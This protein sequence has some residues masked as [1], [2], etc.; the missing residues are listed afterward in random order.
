MCIVI[1][2]PASSYD[3][4]SLR[5]DLCAAFPNLTISTGVPE[6]DHNAPEDQG[7]SGKNIITETP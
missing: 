2:L 6:A 4:K 7:R 3:S 1:R 5:F